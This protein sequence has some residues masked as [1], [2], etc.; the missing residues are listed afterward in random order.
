MAKP[1]GGAV[2]E[3]A[4]LSRCSIEA[5]DFFAA[6]VCKV[7][8]RTGAFPADP[9][10]IARLMWGRASLY[11]RAARC[12]AELQAAGVVAVDHV[13]DVGRW[14]TFQAPGWRPHIPL[15]LRVSVYTR[16]GWRCLRCGATDDLSL[17]HIKPYCLGGPDTL[18][19]L[20]TLC[21]PCNARKGIKTT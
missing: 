1:R 15:S 14:V 4:A 20:Q 8:E 19:N 18:E 10:E 11:R 17:D 12:M 5:H 7:P 3:S 21:V 13:P 16:D 6:F 2:G 9:R